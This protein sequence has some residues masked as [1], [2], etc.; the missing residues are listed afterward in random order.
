MAQSS[1]TNDPECLSGVF[2]RFEAVLK[3]ESFADVDLMSQIRVEKNI[4][5]RNTPH[6]RKPCLGVNYYP[7][8]LL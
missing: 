4:L 7:P 6:I 5:P 8:L 3:V 2:G 1:I